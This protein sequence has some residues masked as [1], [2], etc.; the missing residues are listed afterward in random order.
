MILEAWSETLT[1]EQYTPSKSTLPAA[2]TAGGV[3]AAL[4]I[5]SPTFSLNF[6][7]LSIYNCSTNRG[8]PRTLRNAI[9]AFSTWTIPNEGTSCAGYIY[10]PFPNQ[11]CHQPGIPSGYD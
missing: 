6:R 4:N 1:N 3:N 11:D 5:Y 8:F 7:A 9:N 10:Q 2:L